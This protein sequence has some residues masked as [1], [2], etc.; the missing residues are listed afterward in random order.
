MRFSVFWFMFGSVFAISS[1]YLPEAESR[2]K[3]DYH[4][5]GELSFEPAKGFLNANWRITRWQNGPLKN[6][7]FL[8][9]T[10]TDIEVSGDQIASFSIEASRETPE[11]WTIQIAFKPSAK[12][13]SFQISYRGVLLP[14][15]LDDQINTLDE[16]VIEL[17]IDSFWH[18]VDAS[19]SKHLT[20][21][22]EIEIGS[23]W[24]GISSGEV[25]TTGK[26]LR[27]DNTVPMVDIAFTLARNLQKHTYSEFTIFDLRPG[28]VSH[29]NLVQAA[30][31]CIDFLNRQFGDPQPLPPGRFVISS[32]EDSGYARKNYIVFTDI[33]DMPQPA[34]IDFVAHE[35]AHFWSSAGNFATVENWLNESFA[36]YAGLMAVRS[37]LGEAAYRKELATIREKTKDDLPPIWVPGATERGPHAVL[38]RKGPLALAE[39]ESMVGRETFLQFMTTYMTTRK[40]TTP[41]LL[42]DL[43]AIAGKDVREAFTQMLA[44]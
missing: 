28:K 36:V 6:T 5:R 39:L 42:D 30:D 18:P 19:F 16:N 37:I 15:P 35:L 10:L 24:S 26:G 43:E 14:E 38:Y 4:Y 11:F 27:I 31:K 29:Q 7:F 1:P 12:P 8:R 20:A 2:T 22:L 33:R 40:G 25:T 32:R 41:A 13:H 3:A 44:R 23:Q 21:E 17:G 34:L 9:K